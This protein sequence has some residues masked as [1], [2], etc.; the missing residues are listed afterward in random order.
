MKNNFKFF[1]LA[2]LA[3]AAVFTSC[4]DDDSDNGDAIVS[5]LPAV[6]S[7]DTTLVAGTYSLSGSCHVTNGATL[8]I[9][10][11]VTIE[12]VYDSVFDY[13]LIEQGAKIYAVGEANNPIVMTSA[14]ASDGWGGLHLC[15]YAPINGGSTT[16]L[17]E[18]G[19]STYGGTSSTDNS[20]T[21]KYVRIENSGKTISSEKEANGFSFY[22]VGSGT[23]VS[24]CQAYGGSDDGF[25]FF[26]GTVNISY[27]VVVDCTDDSFDWTQ[28]W[29][30]SA[31]YI[32][33]IQSEGSDCDC[34]ME[35]DNSGSNNAYTP[36]SRPTIKNATLIGDGDGKG[37]RLRE[38]TQV[39]LENV[40]VANAASALVVE[41]QLT[42]ASLTNV[43]DN[44]DFSSLI[45]S[46]TSTD[47]DQSVL[48]SVAISSDITSTFDSTYDTAYQYTSSMFTAAG[49]YTNQA[50]T[51][52]A[53][54]YILTTSDVTGAFG[55]SDWTEG[56]W[57]I[58]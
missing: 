50:F 42:H 35:C 30:G 54:Y 39:E 44:A 7:E 21:L 28:G 53:E 8:T 10:P 16:A 40:I 23:S 57:C 25:E 19:E 47:K 12:A 49:N 15:G 55:G 32:L 29:R 34:L 22:G 37:I 18:I 51:E 11:G 41:S 36:V 14:N 9:K 43:W 27:C 6:I 13:I 26:G 5:E 46:W 2:A 3:A 58:L 20:G 31:N 24:Y 33:A 38:G 48:S 52:G 45:T 1:T 4:S 56:A 17:S